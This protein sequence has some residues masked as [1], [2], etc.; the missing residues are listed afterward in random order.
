LASAVDEVAYLDIWE[1]AAQ[2]EWVTITD[3]RR[4]ID[5]AETRADLDAERVGLLGFSQGAIVASSVVA[6]EPRLAATA[7]VMGGTLT[8]Q[9]LARCPQDRSVAAKARAATEFGWTLDDLEQRLEPMFAPIDAAT[10]PGRVDPSRVLIVEAARDECVPETAREALWEAMGRPERI[11]LGYRH[12]QAFLAMTP[13]GLN[14]LPN[15][16]WHFFDQALE[17]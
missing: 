5:W 12:K 6:Q 10:Y 7:L 11:K 2:R 16:I 1:Q 3:I 17:P 15:R 13:L 4:L 8:H 14:W 9:V